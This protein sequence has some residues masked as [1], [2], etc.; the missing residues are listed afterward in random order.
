MNCGGL[1]T[2]NRALWCSSLIDYFADIYPTRTDLQAGDE[3]SLP[4]ACQAHPVGRRPHEACKTN[5]PSSNRLA[6]LPHSAPLEQTPLPSAGSFS[7]LH[8]TP[9]ART[10]LPAA[11]SSS[12]QLGS[13]A[14]ETSP[15]AAGFPS[16]QP[17]PPEAPSAAH[18]S[19]VTTTTAEDVSDVIARMKRGKT[20]ARDN[21]VSEML[22]ALP[23]DGIVRLAELLDCL[24]ADASLPL[25]SFWTEL[26]AIL[27]PKT[28]TPE[29]WKDFRPI[30][31]CPTLAKTWDSVLLAKFQQH[32]IP[33][34]SEW[35]H[36]FIAGRSLTGPVH[37]L[38]TLAEKCRGWG[39][40]LVCL[41]LDVSKAFDRV[42]HSA[43]ER[44]ERALGS[45]GVPE[46][47]ICAVVKGYKNLTS[48]FRLDARVVSGEVPISRGVRQ[49]SPLSPFL[50]A[51]VLNTVLEELTAKW[52]KKGWGLKLD[53]D[54]LISHLAFG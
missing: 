43:I 42:L 53:L 10:P 37:I 7:G 47:L 28:G 49:G 1:S 26:E 24:L 16:G 2:S 5:P 27:L 52:S 3:T 34:L 9:S 36:A 45:H 25:P 6:P 12:G 39:R 33:N 19:R 18:S 22:Q 29:T 17:G 23:L 50:F 54:S 32:V 8:S 30:T 35:Q 46:D 44:L 41:K 21:V 14:E 20:C 51:V 4:A 40:K 13:P 38:S 11:G 15:P 31:I 48:T